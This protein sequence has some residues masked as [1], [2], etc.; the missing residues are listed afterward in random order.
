MYKSPGVKFK[1]CAL[2]TGLCGSSTEYRE[3]E[4]RMGQTVV[5]DQVQ[6]LSDDGKSLNLDPHSGRFLLAPNCSRHRQS[7]SDTR[8]IWVR[9]G[10]RGRLRK[11]LRATVRALMGV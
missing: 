5:K 7:Y 4:H 3:S 9:E 10:E 8:D 6:P 2:K 1:D 11:P